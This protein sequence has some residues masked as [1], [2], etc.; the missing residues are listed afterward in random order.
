MRSPEPGKNG[1]KNPVST[2]KHPQ[3]S[4]AARAVK[5]GSKGAVL[6]MDDDEY[7]GSVIR[8]MLRNSGYRTRIAGT[9]DEAVREF[10][11]ARSEQRPY[12]AVILDLNM[13]IGLQ[14][15]QAMKRL[16]GMD[17]SV[18]AIL[19]TGDITHRAVSDYEEIGFRAV[20][21]K[22]FTQEELLQAIQLTLAGEQVL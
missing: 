8:T 9:S 7:V 2:S 10:E 20:L 6:V 5:A 11:S 1:G 12:D 17:P 4:R 15:D 21:L 16:K 22:P 3:R 13:P 18:K 19:L 14:G